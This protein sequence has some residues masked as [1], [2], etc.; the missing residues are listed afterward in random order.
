M[1]HHTVNTYVISCCGSVMGILE[2]SQIQ[3]QCQGATSHKPGMVCT[4]AATG[5]ELILLN[6]ECARFTPFWSVCSSDPLSNLSLQCCLLECEALNQREKLKSGSIDK[7]FATKHNFFIAL[8][9]YFSAMALT[10]ELLSSP[11][12]KL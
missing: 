6:W 2:M 12:F 8:R 5:M 7:K 4:A 9:G 3:H 10:S 1:F 11:C